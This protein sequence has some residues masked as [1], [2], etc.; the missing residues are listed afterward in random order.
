MIGRFWRATSFF[1][2]CI[3]DSYRVDNEVISLPCAPDIMLAA[4]TMEGL[5]RRP[6]KVIVFRTMHC[7]PASQR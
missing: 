1:W 7:G 3:A 4:Q 2:A 6:D 5:L